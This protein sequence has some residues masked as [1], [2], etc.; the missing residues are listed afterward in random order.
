MNN[1]KLTI[2]Y[3]GTDYHGWQLQQ[4]AKTVQEELVRAIEIL[5][6]EKVNLVGAGRTDAGVHALGQ[7]ANFRAET[8]IDIYR[9]VHSLNGIL[10][11]DISIKKMEKATDDF[12]SRFDAKT[13][14]Y[15]YLITRIKSPFFYKYTYLYPYDL[16]IERLRTFS[17]KFLGEHDFEAFTKELPQTDHCRCTIFNAGWKQKEDVLIF[18]IEANRFLH[19]MVRA[20]TGTILTAEK[21]GYPDEWIEEI[22]NSKDR[23]RAGFAVPSQGLYL[24]KIK[25]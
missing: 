13:R 12:H 25:Y 9:F 22:F 23:V 10:P 4:N 19:G 20:I 7:V 17:G 14:T 6:K 5:V 1:Y 18:Y 3:D 2:Q 21:N 15:W 8:D 11:K 24:A 16:D